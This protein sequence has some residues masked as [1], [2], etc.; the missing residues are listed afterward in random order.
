MPVVSPEEALRERVLA[1]MP[2]IAR[3]NTIQGGVAVAK[4]FIAEH[5][6]LFQ[7]GPSELFAFLSL[8]EC[9][10]CASEQERAV[11]DTEEWGLQVGG[12]MVIGTGYTFFELD[13]ETFDEPTLA[14][15]FYLTEEPYTFVNAAG[16]VTR[17][18]DRSELRAAVA[19][20]VRDGIWRVLAFDFEEVEPTEV[21]EEVRELLERGPDA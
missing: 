5:P 14:V 3:T 10:Y 11:R 12:D 7:E 4:A 9:E 16:E 2:S 19:L 21:P 13:T 6:R 18:G 20:Q 8:P 1:Q 15:A 17:E